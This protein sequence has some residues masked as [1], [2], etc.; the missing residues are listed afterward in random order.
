[1]G[2]GWLRGGALSSE[3]AGRA[4]EARGANARRLPLIQPS[5]EQGAAPSSEERFD[6]ALIAEGAR[7]EGLHIALVA[8]NHRVDLGA[9]IRALQEMSQGMHHGATE[10]ALRLHRFTLSAE[11]GSAVDTSAPPPDGPLL[12]IGAAAFA[13]SL[14]DLPILITAGEPAHRWSPAAQALRGRVRLIV[15]E[16]TPALARALR[17][18]WWR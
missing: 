18:R 6:P 12:S 13:Y 5:R 11:G 2:G 10:D 7:H 17:E 9:S 14:P 1:M 15:P 16:L 4:Q 8:A 3:E